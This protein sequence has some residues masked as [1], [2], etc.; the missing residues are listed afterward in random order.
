MEWRK[1]HNEE[2]NDLHSLPNNVRVMKST[3]TRCAG[4]VARVRRCEAHTRFW[5][6]NVR[7]RT[8]LQDPGIDGRIMIR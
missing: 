2:L 6:G 4:H 8:H 5:W 1:L 7:E 3:K